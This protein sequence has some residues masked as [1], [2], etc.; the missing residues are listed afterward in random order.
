MTPV[1]TRPS[2]LAAANYLLLKSHEEGVPLTLERLLSLLYLAD[3]LYAPA[4]N[5]YQTMFEEDVE[6]WAWGPVLPSIMEAFR[7]HAKGYISKPP[8]LGKNKAADPAQLSEMDRY[9]LNSVW[10]QFG[11][12]NDEKVARLIIRADGP[13]GKMVSLFGG[14]ENVRRG[15]VIPKLQI[16]RHFREN[17]TLKELT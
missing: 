3:G 15:T 7:G 12:E 14:I 11:K 2:P 6:A 5:S 1:K 13:W 9:V 16:A 8:D 4:T 17:T 10:A